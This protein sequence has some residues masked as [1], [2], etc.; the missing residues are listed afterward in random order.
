M[1]PGL[2]IP[3]DCSLLLS[4]PRFWG[5][6]PGPQKGIN[7]GIKRFRQW[8]YPDAASRNCQQVARERSVMTSTRIETSARVIQGS[9]ASENAGPDR[10]ACPIDL[11][12]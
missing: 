2:R 9:H 10:L 4:P 7:K 1:N 3:L 6:M 5:L 12:L 11:D 8:T